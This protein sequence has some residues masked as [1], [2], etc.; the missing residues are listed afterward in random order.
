MSVDYHKYLASREWSVKR[1]AIKR[2]S[3]GMCERCDL[4]PM[5]DVH[6]LTYEHIYHEPLEDLQAICR[7]CHAFESGIEDAVDPIDVLGWAFDADI[8]DSDPGPFGTL[9]PGW[10]QA[11]DKH[12]I[13]KYGEEWEGLFIR[14]LL[15]H[16][17]VYG[18]IFTT[19][20]GD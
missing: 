6:H 14:F 19:P 9:E 7:P 2:R 16:A 3:K 8:R 10:K 20:D 15:A 13:A 4:F 12:W 1:E 17:T 11:Q 5:R 18:A